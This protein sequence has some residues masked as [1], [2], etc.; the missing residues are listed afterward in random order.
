MLSDLDTEIAKAFCIHCSTHHDTTGKVRALATL[1][2][3]HRDKHDAAYSSLKEDEVLRLA[4]LPFIQDLIED[5]QRQ[6]NG[7]TL[8]LKLIKDGKIVLENPRA[9]LARSVHAA[10]IPFSTDL[11]RHFVENFVKN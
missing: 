10:H 2:R 4:V 1:Y 11:V 7:F 6:P 9:G 8:K 3:Q 5:F